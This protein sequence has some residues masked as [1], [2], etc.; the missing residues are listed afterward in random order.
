MCQTR[1]VSEPL[2]DRSALLH[3]VSASEPCTGRVCLAW[4]L[5]VLALSATLSAVELATSNPTLRYP[6]AFDYAQLGRQL[7]SGQGFTTLETYPYVLSRLAELGVDTGAPWPASSRFPLPI[8]S[9]AVSYALL[10]P[11]DL[12]ALLPAWCASA[13]TAPLVFLLAN[14][15]GGPLA[16]LLSAGLWLASLLASRA[17]S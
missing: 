15:L 17:V 3:A 7:W 12:A 1:P 6:D 8:V 9:A 5:L 16:G 13:L 10:G 4:T 2:R 11:N 14:R